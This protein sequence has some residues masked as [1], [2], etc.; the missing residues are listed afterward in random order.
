MNS[1]TSNDWSME[2]MAELLAEVCHETRDGQPPIFEF[3]SVL[4]E[5]IRC[6]QMESVGIQSTQAELEDYILKGMDEVRI[7]VE[8]DSPDFERINQLRREAVSRWGDM[9]GTSDNASLSDQT[10]LRSLHSQFET[11]KSEGGDEDGFETPSAETI[12]ALLS[13]LGSETQIPMERPAAVEKSDKFATVGAAG[14]EQLDPELREAFMD[15]ASSCLSSLQQALLRLESNAKDAES[16]KQILREL[17]TLK[18]ASGSVGLVDLAEQIHQLEETLRED[19]AAGREPSVDQL[20]ANVE[21]IRVHIGGNNLASMVEPTVPEPASRPQAE[22]QSVAVANATCAEEKN[23]EELVR[24]K[25]SQ[26]NRLMD[27]LVELV[28]LRNQRETELSE[29]QGVYHELISSASKMRLL[30]SE[31]EL[32]ANTCTSLQLSEVA[33]DVLEAAQHIRDCAQPF[34]DGNAAVSR[35]IRQFRQE[36]VELRR[37]PISG[38]FRRLQLVARDAAC[39]G[40]AS[41]IST[42]R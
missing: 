39:R 42:A 8:A 22:R 19:Q 11:D 37:T 10:W 28:M 16:L 35:F 12:Q 36:L 20:L 9:F 30:N 18:G 41:A 31:S 26:L 2:E 17:H 14:I 7:A 4:V 25:S 38:L 33:N 40:E 24:V 5:L 29:L 15:D 6:Y 32:R 23:D 21:Q 27:M 13:Q 34:A 3:A 1:I